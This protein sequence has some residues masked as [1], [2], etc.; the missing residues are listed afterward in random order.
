LKVG[1]G[2]ADGELDVTGGTDATALTDGDGEADALGETLG[3]VVGDADGLADGVGEGFGAPLFVGVGEGDGVGATIVN[4]ADA[5]DGAL[6]AIV[7]RTTWTPALRC[8]DGGLKPDRVARHEP[9]WVP[10]NATVARDTPSQVNVAVPQCPW[11]VYETVAANDV[12]DDPWFGDNESVAAASA[13]PPISTSA[14][15]TQHARRMD[16]FADVVTSVS[17]PAPR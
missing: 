8:P 11:V 5:L 6:P 10:G 15:A 1:T 9:T 12:V 3:E 17:R 7:A 13:G 4:V 2:D 16:R 14:S